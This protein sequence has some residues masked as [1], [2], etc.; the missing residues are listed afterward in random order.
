MD[1]LGFVVVARGY[2]LRCDCG[3]RGLYGVRG[4]GRRTSMISSRGKS[5]LGMSV[6]LHAIR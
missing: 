4:G 6:A 5:S 3:E 1:A 2:D